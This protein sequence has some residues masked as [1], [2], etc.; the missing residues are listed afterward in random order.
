MPSSHRR[1]LSTLMFVA[2]STLPKSETALKPMAYASDG[3]IC[4]TGCRHYCTRWELQSPGER[5]LIHASRVNFVTIMSARTL[6]S[7]LMCISHGSTGRHWMKTRAGWISRLSLGGL[8][9]LPHWGI[10]DSRARFRQ[11]CIA[12]LALLE[13]IVMP[14]GCFARKA[15][16]SFQRAE[17]GSPEKS[18]LAKFIGLSR[19]LARMRHSLSRLSRYFRSVFWALAR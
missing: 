3:R 10:P 19:H 14:F 6:N 8:A 4:K 13:E 18:L 17:S 15:R 16:T 2:Y 5:Q 7:L 12:P 9:R 11:P 1:I